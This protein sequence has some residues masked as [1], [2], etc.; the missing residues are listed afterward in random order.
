[1]RRGPGAC[2]DLL[3]CHRASGEGARAV[4]VRANDGMGTDEFS[5]VNGVLGGRWIWT[6]LLSSG[7]GT[8]PT[9]LTTASPTCATGARSPSTSRTRSRTRRCSRCRV[10]S[11]S[12]TRRASSRVSPTGA[13][14][15]LATGPTTA[16]AANGA[17]V[18]WR[19]NGVA[20]TTTLSLPS[21]DRA[22]A[23]PRARTVGRCKP[24]GGARLV[25]RT[26]FSPCARTRTGGTSWVCRLP[27]RQDLP[28][29]CRRGRHAGFGPSRGLHQAGPDRRFLRRRARELART[30][31]HVGGGRLGAA[32]EAG[33][34]GLR[35]WAQTQ[36]A[37]TILSSAN[38]PPRWRWW[39]TSPTPGSTR[40]AR[41]ARST[42]RPPRPRRAGRRPSG[43]SRPRC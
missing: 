19:L 26:D 37:A 30:R 11:W 15:L 35:A 4:D 13:R 28:A 21:A 36:P 10:C 6:T 23:R 3:A 39:A 33:P 2:V 38:R 8:P 9:L 34:G 29:R 12:P 14:N 17:R 31:E 18:Y 22:P 32:G 42:C 43:G 7:A 27:P 20:Q 41:R 24:R 25:L 16:L 40:P 5:V 1:M